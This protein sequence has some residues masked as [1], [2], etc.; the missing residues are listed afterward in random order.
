[1]GLLTRYQRNRALFALPVPPP[2]GQ[3]VRT[4]L[5][6]DQ[7]PYPADW[8]A[9][10]A[11]WRR[12]ACAVRGRTVRPTYRVE[13]PYRLKGAADH[14]VFLLVVKGVDRHGRTVRRE[15]TDRLISAQAT[16][17]GGGALPYP[18]ADLLAWAWQRWEIEVAHREQKTTFGLGEVQG[19]GATATVTTTQWTGWLSG[20][21]VLTGFLV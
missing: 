4:L 2:A 17:D 18:A 11:G 7:A 14:P 10:P 12:T 20:L 6:G 21:V 16:A 8:L 3:R 15:P 19:W 13:G 9:E 1:V 5:Y